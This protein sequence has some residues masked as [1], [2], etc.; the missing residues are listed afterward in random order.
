M[1]YRTSCLN[2]L[3]I[4]SLVSSVPHIF[5]YFY[6]FFKFYYKETRRVKQIYLTLNL[7]HKNGKTLVV[8]FEISEQAPY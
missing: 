7:K 4:E 5:V 6:L 8:R 2:G 1:A 3:L